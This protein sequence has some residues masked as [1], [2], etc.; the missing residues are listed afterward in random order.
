MIGGIFSEHVQ[1][2]FEAAGF[3]GVIRS[4]FGAGDSPAALILDDPK[5]EWE[6]LYVEG[7]KPR[8]E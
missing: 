6:S 2:H 5:Y 8:G 3:V 7:M 1:E 4:S